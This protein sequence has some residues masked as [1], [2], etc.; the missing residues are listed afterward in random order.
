MKHLITIVLLALLLLGCAS[1]ET[2]TKSTQDTNSGQ[3]TFVGSESSS[4][5]VTFGVSYKD[6]QYQLSDLN[7]KNSIS[8]D[9]LNKKVGANVGLYAPVGHSFKCKTGHENGKFSHCD[10]PFIRTDIAKSAAFQA[11]GVVSFVGLMQ[12]GD[13]AFYFGEW[14]ESEV[15][16]AIDELNL[17]TLASEKVKSKKFVFNKKTQRRKLIKDL[18]FDLLQLNE[19]AKSIQ[20]EN[21]YQETLPKVFS[22]KSTDRTG[23]FRGSYEQAIKYSADLRAAP[24]NI[25]TLPKGIDKAITALKVN[26]IL[27]VDSESE[28]KVF[29]QDFL[30]KKQQYLKVYR[31][32]LYVPKNNLSTDFSVNC[33]DTKLDGF[34]FSFSCSSGKLVNGK[35]EIK[36]DAVVNSYDLGRVYPDYY[37]ENDDFSIKVTGTAIKLTNKTKSFIKIKSL[38]SYVNSDILNTAD[39]GE[40]TLPPLS[41]KEVN[42]NSYL[43]RSQKSQITFNSM[44]KTKI[45]NGK[46]NFGWAVEYQLANSTTSKT[47]FDQKTYKVKS[48]I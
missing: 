36:A 28:L 31:D 48:F 23:L 19:L 9:L 12:L 13:G 24:L 21:E 7:S 6:G 40:I 34:S 45:K 39:E 29:L 38:S 17:Y 32:K 43:S 5:S 42:I 15:F 4:S 26:D 1:T 30:L 10:T 16:K 27:K 22:I 20:S 2:S 8:I 3:Y 11:A 47:L 18:K 35:I 44:D 46:F 37:S 14:D 41:Y 33:R 25:P